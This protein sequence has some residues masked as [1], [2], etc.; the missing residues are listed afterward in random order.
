MGETETT[1]VTKQIWVLL[2]VRSTDLLCDSSRS[3]FHLATKCPKMA[4][5]KSRRKILI[6][7]HVLGD[8]LP[9]AEK[10]ELN[11]SHQ[12]WDSEPR[13]RM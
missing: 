9:T 4:K 5:I 11:Q 10:K 1:T 2:S 3:R 7:Y 12:Q 6:F 13:V 8:C